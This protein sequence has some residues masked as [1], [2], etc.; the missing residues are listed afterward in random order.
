MGIFEEILKKRGMNLAELVPKYENLSDPMLLPD[1]EMAISR[2]R[3]A[4]ERGEKVLI[5]GDYDADG[6]TASAV[7][8]LGLLMAG[9][10][11]LEVMLPDRFVDGYGMN[12]RVVER[13]RA[14]GVRLV[15]TVDCG[16]SNEV[17][18]AELLTVGA[19]TIV[20]DHHEL[21]WGAPE[22]AVAVVNPKRAEYEGVMK[23]LA[24]VGVAFEVVRGLVKAGLV[25]AGQEKW[26]MDLVAVGMIADSMEM[27]GEN[28]QMV[29]LGMKVLNLRRRKGLA[30]LARLAKLAE[31]DSAGVGFRIAPRLNAAGRMAKAE[32]A[33]R[34]LLA[35]TPAE[36]TMRAERLEGLNGERKSSQERAVQGI[37]VDGS[38]VMVVQADCHEG[39]IGIVAG[40]LMEEHQRPVF[41]F[42]EAGEDSGGQKLL[43]CSGR[44]F[45]EFDLAEALKRGED[46]LVKGGGHAA[47]CGATIAA[48]DFAEFKR[49]MNEYYLSLGLTNQERFLAEQAE[50]EKEDLA[51]ID[52][53]LADDLRRLEP[54]GVGNEEP[55]FLLKGMR[56]MEV[57]WLGKESEHLMM[58][59]MDGEGRR[60]K[61]MG[62]YGAEEWRGIEAGDRLDVMV[63]LMVNEWNGKRS[64]EG[65]IVKIS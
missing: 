9:V 38:P 60:M 31:I 11:D 15:I 13:A 55:K 52:V 58:M 10:K 43:K 26:L 62:F 50:I 6:V 30:E 16:S 27:R 28:W 59:V 65:R 32:E 7:M 4:I 48:R 36:A 19:E 39:V 57:K 17:E 51:E 1:M 24:G 8:Y 5:Y 64:V 25:P 35:E 22:S 34:L 3:Q 29:K 21:T 44:S 37:K 49:R 54:F 53:T 61:V 14:E 40:R 56:V 63:A 33:L 46:L 20:T 2:I 41:V 23:G 12:E 18:I 45:G 47:A 42:T